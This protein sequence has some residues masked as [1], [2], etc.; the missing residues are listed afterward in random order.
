[1][2]SFPSYHPFIFYCSFLSSFCISPF[3]PSL[4]RLLP[5]RRQDERMLSQCDSVLFRDPWMKPL[6]SPAR[7]TFQKA[8]KSR[9]AEI[10]NVLGM[11]STP[12][13]CCT[14]LK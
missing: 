3:L 12:Q 11:P 13:C 4:L 7:S 9:F 14:L 1:L 10:R 8:V 5:S 6:H 2:F